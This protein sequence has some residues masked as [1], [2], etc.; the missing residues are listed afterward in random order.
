MGNQ[1]TPRETPKPEPPSEAMLEGVKVN[2]GKLT[3]KRGGDLQLRES[4]IPKIAEGLVKAPARSVAASVGVAPQ[5]I[6][7][8]ISRGEQVEQ[9]PEGA[10]LTEAEMMCWRLHR[11]VAQAQMDFIDKHTA[12][13][14]DIATSPIYHANGQ[15]KTKGD[16]VASMTILERRFSDLYG[17]RSVLS[18]TGPGGSHVLAIGNLDELLS[19]E[20]TKDAEIIDMPPS[21]ND[22]TPDDHPSLPDPE[23]KSG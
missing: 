22:D 16:W 8:W 9:M 6:K 17:R 14:E 15:E 5:T 18:G 10:M 11:A 23:N 12:N 1:W 3:R 7:Q 20:K 4:M 13:I 2:S 19:A 21:K